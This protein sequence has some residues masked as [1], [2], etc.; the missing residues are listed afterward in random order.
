[1]KIE[2][3]YTFA[4]Y[5]AIHRS[6]RRGRRFGRIRDFFI[7]LL[8]AVNFGLGFWFLGLQLQRGGELGWLHFANIGIGLALIFGIFV[9]GPLYRKWYLRQQMMEDKTVTIEFDNEGLVAQLGE[10]TTRTLWPGIVRVD[11]DKTHHLLWI[12]KMQ[13]YSIP[14]R[15]FGEGQEEEFLNLLSENVDNGSIKS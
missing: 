1:M 15:A 12:N 7:L 10:N 9:L 3:T 13:A 4:D 14:K 8:I 11:G 6:M 5:E 2:W